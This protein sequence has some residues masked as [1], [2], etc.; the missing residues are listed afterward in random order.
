MT[1]LHAGVPGIGAPAPTTFEEFWPFF[2]SQ[3]LHPRTRAAHAGG[4]TMAMAS[5]VGLLFRRPRRRWIGLGLA[6]GA[7]QVASHYLWEGNSPTDVD[8][9]ARSPWWIVRAD[10]RMVRDIYLGRVDRDVREVRA[11]LGMSPG[12]ATWS[13]ARR[14]QAA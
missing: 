6:G 2:L 5:V 14:Q 13:R 3:H 1:D 8:R 9:L 7:L 12:D 4:L 11:A 10:V